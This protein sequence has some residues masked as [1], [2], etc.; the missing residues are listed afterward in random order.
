MSSPK[1]FT[2]PGGRDGRH[3][4]VPFPS[5]THDNHGLQSDNRHWQGNSSPGF[6]NRDAAQNVGM[7]NRGP[8]KGPYQHRGRSNDRGQHQQRRGQC[9]PHHGQFHQYRGRSQDGGQG[10][11]SFGSGPRNPPNDSISSQFTPEEIE[12]IKLVLKQREATAAAA[13]STGISGSQPLLGNPSKTAKKKEKEQKQPKGAA[14]MK[15]AVSLE[16]PSKT[17]VKKEKE[18]QQPKG[19]AA[20]PSDDSDSDSDDEEDALTSSKELSGDAG[21][22]CFVKATDAK[23]VADSKKKKKK[24]NKNKGSKDQGTA[25]QKPEGLSPLEVF[26]ASGF[27]MSQFAAMDMNQ[28]VSDV[29]LIAKEDGN[30]VSCQPKTVGEMAEFKEQ[31]PNAQAIIVKTSEQK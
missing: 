7:H 20:M 24:R 27:D 19:A 25:Q 28:A 14:A 15:S 30:M 9:N 11:R 23:P 5:N 17:S 12:A 10:Q 31:Y 4:F 8:N 21:E 18:Q 22:T 26:T 29:M 16:N 13:E 2:Q 3:D 1:P 6:S